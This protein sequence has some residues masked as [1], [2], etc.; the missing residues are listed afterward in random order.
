MSKPKP[1]SDDLVLWLTGLKLSKQAAV[2]VSRRL[3]ESHQFLT[4]QFQQ[5]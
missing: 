2:I 5:V 1:P 4:V 3:P